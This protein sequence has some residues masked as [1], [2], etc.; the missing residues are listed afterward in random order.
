E[1]VVDVDEPKC[2]GGDVLR[3]RRH[4][5]DLVPGEADLFAEDRLLAAERGLRGIEAVKDAADARQ[6]EGAARV[7][8]ADASPGIWAA[9]HAYVEHP[10]QVEVL[11]VDR[12]AGHAR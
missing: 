5:R 3:V 4:G 11:G 2:V 10:R 7:H 6:G 12:R 9:E 8:S 1:L